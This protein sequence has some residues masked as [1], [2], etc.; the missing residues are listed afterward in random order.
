ML[1]MIRYT[2]RLDLTY[3]MMCV[4]RAINVQRCPDWL[5]L[6]GIPEQC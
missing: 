5:V 6:E 3:I 4:T 1:S 2:L